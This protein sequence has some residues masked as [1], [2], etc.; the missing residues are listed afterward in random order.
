[1][2]HREK[3]STEA[4]EPE[5]R[6]TDH[7]PETIAAEADI[8]PK[9]P[10]DEHPA[11]T[12]TPASKAPEPQLGSMPAGWESRLTDDGKVYYIDHNRK[13]TT[14]LDPRNHDAGTV[15]V[16]LP[17]GWEISQTEQGRTYFIDHNTR[18][19]T[20]LDPRNHNTGTVIVGLP[21]GWEIRQTKN[22]R[23]YFI[24]HRTRMT[25]WEDPRSTN[26]QVQGDPVAKP[27][28]LSCGMRSG[29]TQNGRM[30]LEGPNSANRAMASS[31]LCA[32][33]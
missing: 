5:R 23:T 28:D 30:S 33:L 24:D 25:T 7:D 3:P 19:T 2:E 26:A 1:M 17:S 21:S 32:K 8:S 29:E 18:T 10:P 31:P 13:T 4:H 20:W 11:R 6:S 16:G 12:T 15:T 27:D 22:G 9:N 14:W